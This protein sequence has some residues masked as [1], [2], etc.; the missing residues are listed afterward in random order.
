MP[1][2]IYK[3]LVRILKI[4]L[5]LVAIT[6]ILLAV[7][8]I[9]YHRGAHHVFTLWVADDDGKVVCQVKRYWTF[10]KGKRAHK[11]FATDY[12]WRDKKECED[13]VMGDVFFETKIMESVCSRE[14]ICE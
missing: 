1:T 10:H 3:A 13:K 6:T 14:E 11:W 4:T 7:Y 2:R 12:S 5:V 9:G 8:K